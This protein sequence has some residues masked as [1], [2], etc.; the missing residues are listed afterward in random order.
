MVSTHK[1]AIKHLHKNTQEINK[2]AIGQGKGVVT[3]DF[4][5]IGSET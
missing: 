1:I 5:N 4:E 2:Y 3:L